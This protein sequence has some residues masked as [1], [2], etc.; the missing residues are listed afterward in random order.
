MSLVGTIGSGLTWSGSIFVNPM[1]R[2]V[3]N[4]K[5]ISIVGAFIMSVGIFLASFCTQVRVRCIPVLHPL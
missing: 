5:L 1:I 4:V 2:R 3:D